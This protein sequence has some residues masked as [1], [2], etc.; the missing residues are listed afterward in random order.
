MGGGQ[1]AR[2][3]WFGQNVCRDE[4]VESV[5][6]T[7]RRCVCSARRKPEEGGLAPVPVSSRGG[8]SSAIG[9]EP[10]IALDLAEQ[11]LHNPVNSVGEVAEDEHLPPVADIAGGE[12][13][14][15]GLRRD[16]GEHLH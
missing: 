12:P 14:R 11:E 4:Q 1:T 13:L 10:R 2:W 7:P 3:S 5:L 9:A 16:L 6:V 8:D 15:I